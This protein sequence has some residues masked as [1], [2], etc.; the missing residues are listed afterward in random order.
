MRVWFISDTHNH[1]T[2]LRIPSDIQIVVH[3]GDESES[4][5]EWF[6]EPEAREFFDWYSDLPIAIKVFVPGNHS[7]AIEKGLVSPTDY[8]QVHFLIHRSMEVHGLNFFGTP[9]TPKFFNWSYMRSREEL[10]FVWQTIPDQVDILISHGPPK[11]FLDVTCDMHT[12]APIHV[13]SNSLTK[14]VTQRIKPMIHAFGHIH[15]EKEIR[16]FG[17]VLDKGTNFINCSCCDVANQLVNHGFV[18]QLDPVQKSC[19][20]LDS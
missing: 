20:V 19:V 11:G 8:P 3:C 5:N 7:T 18:V 13:G 16:N 14:H 1:H 12:R 2:E 15:D 17:H 10:D 4:G 6:N 9:F